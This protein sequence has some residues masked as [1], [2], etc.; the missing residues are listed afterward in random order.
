MLFLCILY[1]LMKPFTINGVH[2]K[3]F[4]KLKMAQNVVLSNSDLKLRLNNWPFEFVYLMR[5]LFRY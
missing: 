1:A 5:H 3:V 2:I 4:G